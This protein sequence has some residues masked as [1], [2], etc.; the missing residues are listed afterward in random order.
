MIGGEMKHNLNILHCSARHARFAQ[1]RL[2]KLD[3]ACFDVILDVFEPATRKVVDDAHLRT[4]REQCVHEIRADEGRTT[5]YQ[6]SSTVPDFCL[7]AIR[8]GLRV[9]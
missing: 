8:G 9:R 1:V 5:G 4:S 3:T 6:D 7:L 2:D